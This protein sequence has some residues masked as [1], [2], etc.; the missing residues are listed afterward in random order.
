MTQHPLDRPSAGSLHR[1]L[2]VRIAAVTACICVALAVLVYMTERSRFDQAL[3]DSTLHTVA[4]LRGL[5]IDQLDTP[6]LGDHAKIR[7]TLEKFSAYAP[8]G[9]N[10]RYVF[11]R[12]MDTGYATVAQKLDPTY[13]H[14]AAVDRYLAEHRHRFTAGEQEVWRRLVTIAGKPHVHV[15][16]ALADSRGTVVAY[17]EGVYAVSDEA[18]AGIRRRIARAIFLSVAVALAIVALLYPVILR[19]LRRVAT[20]SVHLLQANLTTIQALG[21]AIAK[22]DSDTDLHNYRVTIYSVRLAEALGLKE[23]SIRSLIKGAFLHDVGKIGIGDEILHKPA[24]LTEEE[25]REMKRHVQ[26]GRDIVSNSVWLQ[27][28]LDVVG[29]HHEKYD[30]T[31]YDNRRKSGDIPILAR[32]FAIIDVFDALTSERPYKKPLAIEHT[33]ELLEEGRGTQFDP[34]ILDAFY[35]IAG[36][37]YDQFAATDRETLRKALDAISLRYFSGDIGVMLESESR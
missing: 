18:V 11:A 32:L 6:H 25:F 24:R 23:P 28:A 1:I 10:G 37:L 33:L 5:L 9:T 35:R 16:T 2:I 12:I 34:E 29:G 3:I 20:L 4:N 7:E 21:N 30:G 27:D 36:G 22:R 19:L 13:Q 15:A 26:H 8:R 17:A 31:G 14:Q